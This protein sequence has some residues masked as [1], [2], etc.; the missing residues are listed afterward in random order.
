MQLKYQ[1]EFFMQLREK[2]VYINQ[3]DDYLYY[4]GNKRGT[5]YSIPEIQCSNN[6]DVDMYSMDIF[7][8][9]QI[10][11]INFDILQHR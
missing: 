11:N 10:I 5:N 8:R 4:G 6:E 1:A 2:E 3:P 7:T 9:D